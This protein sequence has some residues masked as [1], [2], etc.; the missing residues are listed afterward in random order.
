MLVV[1]TA[2]VFGCSFLAVGLTGSVYEDIITDGLIAT[3][4][5]QLPFL[6]VRHTISTPPPPLGSFMVLLICH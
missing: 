6:H 4:E 3:G 1:G 2:D 5:L